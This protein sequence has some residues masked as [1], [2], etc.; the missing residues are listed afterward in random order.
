[1]Q[2][3]TLFSLIIAIILFGLTDVLQGRELA[4]LP[5]GISGYILGRSARA[6]DTGGRISA[7]SGAVAGDSAPAAGEA[8]SVSSESGK[9]PD[10]HA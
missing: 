6:R 2:F 9:A 1:L 3:I 5:G 4:A 8:G 10:E 7:A